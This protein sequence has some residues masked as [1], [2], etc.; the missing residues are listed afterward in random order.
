M[1]DKRTTL[2]ESAKRLFS[3]KGLKETS[4][5]EITRQAGVAVGTFY[6]YFPSKDR[7]FIEIFKDEN[8]RMLRW[9]MEGID[10][11]GEPRAV[12]R[13]LLERNMQGMMA[14]PILRQWFDPDALARIERLFRQE[15]GLSAVSFLYQHFLELVRAWQAQGKMRSDIDAQMIMAIFGAIIR[16]GHHRDEIG[17]E[18]F[19][20][21][22]ERLTE[23]VLDGLTRTQR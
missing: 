6:I 19:P 15:D 1:D 14:S 2:Y 21:L 16:I 17:P 4:I 13:R 9:A 5:Q 10:P 23:F 12:I 20:A 18:F 8:E 7:L 22:Q 11:D 3:E